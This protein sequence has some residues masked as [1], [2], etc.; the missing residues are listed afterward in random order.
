MKHIAKRCRITLRRNINRNVQ[1]DDNGNEIVEET[2][3]N[4]DHCSKKYNT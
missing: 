3:H 2:V 4:V 1:N